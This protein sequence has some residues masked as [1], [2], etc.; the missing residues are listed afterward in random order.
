MGFWMCE[1]YEWLWFF[2]VFLGGH[3]LQVSTSTWC[4][5]KQRGVSVAT[6]SG[7]GYLEPKCSDEKWINYVLIS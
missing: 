5:L 4:W 3:Q 7:R 1:G 6:A 2:D